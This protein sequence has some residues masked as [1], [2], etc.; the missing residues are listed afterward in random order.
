MTKKKKKKNKKKK[1]KK[2]QKKKTRGPVLVAISVFSFLVLE[3]GACGHLLVSPPAISSFRSSGFEIPAVTG[4]ANDAV[5]PVKSPGSNLESRISS[6]CTV[7][8]SV[9]GQGIGLS[10]KWPATFVGA[11]WRTWE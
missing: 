6:R 7:S 5:P 11:L 10:E 4:D 8:S 9:I 2:K 1:K 3:G